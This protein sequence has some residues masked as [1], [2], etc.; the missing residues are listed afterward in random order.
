MGT[1]IN[2]IK[3]LSAGSVNIT[4]ST[5]F[6][7]TGANSSAIAIVPAVN[8]VKVTISDVLITQNKQGILAGPTGAATATVLVDRLVADNTAGPAIRANG[9]G[10]IRVSNSVVTNNNR[11]LFQGGNGQIISAGNN[12]ISGNATDGAFDSTVPLQ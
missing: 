9:G 10:T 2:G 7:F 11:G 3:I 8:P 1:G 6:G 4:R 12:F 5:I